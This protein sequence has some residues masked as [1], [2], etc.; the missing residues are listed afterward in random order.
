[1]DIE[2]LI[3][4]A[5]YSHFLEIMG[6]EY[7]DPVAHHPFV[8]VLRWHRDEFGNVELDDYE[9]A[10]V[11]WLFNLPDHEQRGRIPMEFFDQMMRTS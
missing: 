4:E 3:R 6:K 2:E 7:S 10:L 9:T 1:M 5:F 11:G 8:R